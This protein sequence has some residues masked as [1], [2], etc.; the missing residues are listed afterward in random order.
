MQ[1]HGFIIEYDDGV[2]KPG[3]A[4]K[5]NG[6]IVKLVIGFGPPYVVKSIEIGVELAVH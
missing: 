1:F 5:V 3:I 4:V 6:F 2:L